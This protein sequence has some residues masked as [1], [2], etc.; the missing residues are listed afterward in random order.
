L[1]DRGRTRRL[2]EAVLSGDAAATLSQLDEAH[3]LGV[4][5]ASLLR[6]LMETVHA[7]TRA[8]AGASS[9]AL[10]SA[11]EREA[12]AEWASKLNWAAIHRLWQMMLKGLNDVAVAPEP[13]EAAAMALLRLIHA[14][15]M[16]DPAQLAARLAA[17]PA[18]GPA[19]QQAPSAPAP[20]PASA[21]PATFREVVER[22]ADNG[23]RILAQELHDQV[24]LVSF[25]PPQL[26]L[27]PLRPL[28]ADWS[29]DLAAALKEVTGT[30]WSVSFTDQGGEPSLQQQERMA[31]EAMRTAVLEEPAVRAVLESFPEASLESFGPAQT[32][33]E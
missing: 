32:A 24:G 28:G 12:A 31:E 3:E 27:K 5:P 23:K 11:E 29:R 2:L 4:D 22:L 33:R 8:K 20:G 10:Q 16:P 21:A 15:D 18:A 17:G 7:V 26:V 6:G 1:A 25:A 30:R 19:P 9:D 13:Q 14:A